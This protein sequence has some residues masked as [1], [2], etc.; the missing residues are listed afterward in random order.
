MTRK[1]AKCYAALFAFIEEE[2]VELKPKEIMTDYESGMRAAIRKCWPTATLRG[3][4][5][6]FCRAI[7]KRCYKHNM[8]RL[9]MHCRDAKLIKKAIM[10]LPLLPPELIREL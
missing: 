1:T 3:C 8:T 7:R 2:L 9:L 10:S 5:F 4:W 6:H